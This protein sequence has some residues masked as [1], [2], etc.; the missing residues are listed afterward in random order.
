MGMSHVYYKLH[1]HS[2]A[3]PLCASHKPPTMLWTPEMQLP[4]T[5]DK[6]VAGLMQVRTHEHT[7]LTDTRASWGPVCVPLHWHLSFHSRNEW[8]KYL[9]AGK[10]SSAWSVPRDWP[11]SFCLLWHLAS[12]QTFK[13]AVQHHLHIQAFLFRLEINR[14]V[15]ISSNLRL[16]PLVTIP[17]VFSDTKAVRNPKAPL[18]AA[19]S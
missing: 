11:L 16:S 12:K 7:L 10:P 1:Q 2:T 6:W 13:Q 9:A 19:Q 8:A 5:G 14:K 17:L 15:F 4:D 18:F 3:S